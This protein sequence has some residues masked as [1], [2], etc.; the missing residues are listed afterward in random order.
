[1]AAARRGRR[2]AAGHR[3]GARQLAVPVLRQRKAAP[4]P[5]P[6][7]AKPF[8]ILLRDG[9]GTG[10]MLPHGV[11]VP[12]ALAHLVPARPAPRPLA[13]RL[14]DPPGAA[15]WLH[16]QRPASPVRTRSRCV[17]CRRRRRP[18]IPSTR[19]A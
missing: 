4:A 2:A 7:K 1:M 18:A 6:A 9:V 12:A 5:R 10:I 8:S 16:G 11:P 13:F 17:P 19:R 15:P 3:R 14:T